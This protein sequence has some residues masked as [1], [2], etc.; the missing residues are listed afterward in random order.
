MNKYV[1]WTSSV[2]LKIGFYFTVVNVSGLTPG[3]AVKCVT[4]SSQCMS[5]KP[6]QGQTISFLTS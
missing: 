5:S 1:L 6:I 3:C 4:V 2:L